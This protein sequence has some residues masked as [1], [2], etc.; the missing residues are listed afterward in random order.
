MSNRKQTIKQYI[1]NNVTDPNNVFM[2]DCITWDNRTDEELLKAA[3]DR[4]KKIESVYIDEKFKM[5]LREEF[6]EDVE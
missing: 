1:I 5:V 6:E 2:E 4:K 3:K